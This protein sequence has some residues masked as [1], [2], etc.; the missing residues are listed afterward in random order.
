MDKNFPFN[1]FNQNV[2]TEATEQLKQMEAEAKEA[3]EI[4]DKIIVF[5]DGLT[6][7][8]V[9]RVL[10]TVRGKCNEKAVVNCKLGK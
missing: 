7:E 2:L 10:M 1:L 3:N 6:L 5:L 9:E 4:A 8:E